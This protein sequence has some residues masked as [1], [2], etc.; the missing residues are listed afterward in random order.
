MKPILV[1]GSHRSGSTWAGKVISSAPHIA[2]IREPFNIGN[3]IGV[4]PKPFKYWFQYI[5]EF[6]SGDYD[7]VF[8]RI[9]NY[10]Y[11]LGRNITKIKTAKN[12]AELVKD[13]GMFLLH[14]M[15]HD[16]PLIKD[17]IA[18]FSTEWL[19]KTFN[20]NVL[21]MIRHPAAF[22]SSLKIKN[23]KFNFN[24]FLSQPLLIEKY[25]YPFEDEIQE[26]TENEKSII[27]QAIL[28][29][30]CIHHTVEIYRQTH[31]DWLYVKHEYLSAD[32]VR[33]FQSIFKEL[34]LEFTDKT[35]QFIFASSGSHNP[36]EQQAKSKIYRNSK[37]NI[38]NWKKRLTQ[39]EISQ[40]KSKTAAIAD[41][42]YIEDDW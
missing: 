21:I 39:E 8:G 25:L 29:W 10:N 36:I 12:V 38:K 4:N 2:Y 13:Q 15:N 3:K 31:P 19:C 30:N 18:F 17:P 32:P 33:Q 9:I 42:F 40:I 14:K 41:S 37:E 6:N 5:C 28:L 11:P 16:R 24:N 35:K 26:Y 7:S 1:T 34:D 27:D 22:C 23:W 20:M